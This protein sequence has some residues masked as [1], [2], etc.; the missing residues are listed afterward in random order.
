MIDSICGGT[1]WTRIDNKAQV[2]PRCIEYA[3]GLPLKQAQRVLRRLWLKCPAT[4]E[5]QKGDDENAN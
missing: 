1:G 4:G 2:C 3:R 5:Q